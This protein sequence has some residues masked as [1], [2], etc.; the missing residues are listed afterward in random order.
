MQTETTEVADTIE[1]PNSVEEDINDG[2]RNS[3]APQTPPRKFRQAAIYI[4]NQV[5]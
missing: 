4:L 5:R 2:Q 1:T 3:S